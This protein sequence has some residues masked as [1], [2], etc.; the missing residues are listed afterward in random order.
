VI[1]ADLAQYAVTGVTLGSI[2][3]LVALGFVTVYSVTGIINF[4]QGEFVMLGAMLATQLLQQG[5]PLPIAAILAVMGTALVGGLIHE[6]ALR[7]AWRRVT[8]M[9]MIM[10]TI[11]AA[12]AV[13]GLALLA[14]GTD[15][16][17]MSAFTPG[18]PIDLGG[19]VI[20]RQ[21]LWVI[22]VTALA[23]LTLFVFFQ[24]T[25][26]G[27]A[28]RACAVNPIAA[29]LVGISPRRMALASFVLSGAIGALGGVV[30]API[31]FATY[32]MGL[33]LGLKG[34]VGAVLGGLANPAGAVAGGLILGLLESAA[35]PISSAYKDALAFVVL[36]VVMLVR[37]GGL[38]GRSIARGGL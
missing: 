12:T 8:A 6:L 4:A 3:A 2:Y 16:R 9:G 36:I 1:P 35:T 32:D 33:M 15:P 29:R 5:V 13:R 38:F 31:T 14:W 27:R 25:A 23:L 26:L 24:R 17:P 18:P 7:P 11:G 34:F 30:L 37:P 22:A 28:L 20:T 10:I 19:A 21:A